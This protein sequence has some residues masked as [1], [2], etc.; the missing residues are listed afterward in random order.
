MKVFFEMQISY[1]DTFPT[2]ATGFC[3]RQGKN[4]D[5]TVR[6][7]QPKNKGLLLL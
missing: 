2:N 7:G 4:H 6:P 1:V 5:G 3:P